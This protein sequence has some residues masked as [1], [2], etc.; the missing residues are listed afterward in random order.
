LFDST[1]IITILGKRGSGKTTLSQRVQRVYPRKIIIDRLHEYPEGYGQAVYSWAEFSHYLL[2]FENAPSFTLVYKFQ[3]GAEHED[4]IFDEICRVCYHVGGLLLVIEEVWQFAEARAPLSPWFKEIVLTGR[5]RGLALLST[6][7]RPAEVHKTV[8][9]QSSV[10]F[11]GLLYET[12][13]MKYLGEFMGSEVDKLASVPDY[14]FLCY[15]PGQE[16]ILVPN[17]LQ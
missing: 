4:L 8:L 14:H 16:T 10:I 7:Q 11:S 9:S 15:R 5:H 12:N 6:S 1:S 2:A 17:T 13:D 3:V